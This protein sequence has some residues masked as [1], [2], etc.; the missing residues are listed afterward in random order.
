MPGPSLPPTFSYWWKRSRPVIKRNRI[1]ETPKVCTLLSRP[2]G[3]TIPENTHAQAPSHR[4]QPPEPPQ[5]AANTPQPPKSEALGIRG[6]PPEE[7]GTV[8]GVFEEKD[9]WSMAW[10][11]QCSVLALMD[12]TELGLSPLPSLGCTT[13]VRM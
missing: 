2:E 8:T 9:T 3:A 5:S 4:T 13:D 1:S 7:E 6:E 10:D 11:H 12:Q